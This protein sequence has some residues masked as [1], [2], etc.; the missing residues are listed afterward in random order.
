MNTDHKVEVA[1]KSLDFRSLRLDDPTPTGAQLARA[2]GFRANDSVVVLQI[3][4]SGHLESISPEELADLESGRRFIIDESDRS[5]RLTINGSTFDWI[6]PRISGTQ[7][8]FVGRVPDTESLY[9]AKESEPDQLISNEDHVDLR[10]RNAEAIYSKKSEWK[11]NVQGVVVAYTSPTVSVRQALVDVGFDPEAGWII[12]L[13][14]KGEKN[15]RVEL[16]FEIDLRT[17][18]IEKIRL[19]PKDV[20]NGDCAATNDFSLLAEDHKFLDS[21]GLQ[22]RTVL[23]GGKRWL[24]VE[25]FPLPDGYTSPETS[26]ALLIPASYPA[27]QIDMFYVHPEAR[28]ASGVSIAATNSHTQIE[29]CRYTRWS[30]HRSGNSTWNPN[31]D[32]VRTQF[33]LVEGALDREVAT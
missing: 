4:A 3:T 5:F 31:R 18:G 10:G 28:L 13:K 1:T 29:G 25:K 30:R 23:E 8:R 33:A 32:N 17:R 16:D 21:L 12:H 7:I 26:V 24:I 14:V 11:L 27:A 15:A 20:N 6:A 22:W 19:T 9:L 2:A